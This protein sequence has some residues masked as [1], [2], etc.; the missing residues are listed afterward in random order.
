MALS[1]DQFAG[2]MRQMAGGALITIELF[3]ASFALALLFGTLI[4]IVTQ[5]RN[6]VVRALWK[7]YASIFTGVPSLLVIFLVYY[8]GSAMMTA[9]FGRAKPFEVTPFGAGLV[10][11]TIVYA[12]YVAD[13]VHGAVQ[14]LPR[15]QFEAAAA[16]AIRP[17]HAWTYVILPQLARL[18]L[19]GLIN[20]WLVMLKDTPLVSL[21]GLND[22]VAHSKLAA[23]ATKEP[24]V[25]FVIASLFFIAFSWVSLAATRRLEMRLAR[26]MAEVKS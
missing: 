22:I 6:P 8:G 14:N 24:F 11:L 1:S 2:Y 9:L 4:G 26:G 20:V 13:L 3:A 19:P 21:A 18:A 12:A 5:T 17:R 23:G 25:F 15:G 16:L 7:S 10:S